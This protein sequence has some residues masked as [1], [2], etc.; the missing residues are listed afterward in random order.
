M[1]IAEISKKYNISTDTLRYYERIGLIPPVHRNESGYRDY[2]E[3]DEE[4]VYFVLAMRSAG[5]SVESLIEYITL[6]QD[7]IDTI[8]ARKQILIDQRDLLASKISDM[9][10]VLDRL[11]NKI[12]GY[13]DRLV[14]YEGK[15]YK[16]G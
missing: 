4:W 9:Q 8:P 10:K 16:K 11:N 14:K 13:E 3:E 5:I 12:D 1:T 7:G 2:D 15:L 6:F